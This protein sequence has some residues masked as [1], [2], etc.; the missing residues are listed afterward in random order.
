[1]IRVAVDYYAL[2]PKRHARLPKCP[3]M[4]T[5][6]KIPV[7]WAEIKS[8]LKEMER[9]TKRKTYHI[10]FCA[11]EMAAAFSEM[12][13]VIYS[14]LS[15]SDPGEVIRI[16]AH[17]VDWYYRT[18]EQIIDG[19]DGVWIFP[20]ARMGRIV[21]ELLGR[22]PVHPAWDEFNRI[23]EAAG[24]WYGYG[25]LGAEGVAAWKSTCL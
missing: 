16:M 19:S 1:M 9:W 7:Q 2:S 6:E 20:V 8:C 5:S 3:R 17:C 11:G 25:Q 24:L 18:F 23:A 4:E 22:N 12:L 14:R 10:Y 15:G 13:D 21:D